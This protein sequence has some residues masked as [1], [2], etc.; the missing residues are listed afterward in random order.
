MT[1][2]AHPRKLRSQIYTKL[3]TVASN[4]Y[5]GS[6]VRIEP[7][8]NENNILKAKQQLFSTEESGSLESKASDHG[9]E[10][11]RESS[12]LN[13]HSTSQKPINYG[14]DCQFPVIEQLFIYFTYIIYQYSISP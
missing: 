4:T 3:R 10:G 9:K 14:V 2:R 6:S 11:R 12:K 7:L 13:V 5:E 1:E 8:I